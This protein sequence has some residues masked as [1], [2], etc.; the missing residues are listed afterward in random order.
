MISI[1]TTIKTAKLLHSRLHGFHAKG[2]PNVRWLHDPPPMNKSLPVNDINIM[3]KY[4]VTTLMDQDH[5]ALAELADDILDEDT[6]NKLDTLKEFCKVLA[7]HTTA[8]ELIVYPHLETHET[9][10]YVNQLRRE[11]QETQLELRKMIDTQNIDKFPE[12]WLVLQHHMHSEETKDFPMLETTFS[13]N[14]IFTMGY[15]FAAV[16]NSLSMKD[17]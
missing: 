8:E 2:L 4:K 11:H 7:Q 5:D 13:E 10:E 3:P 6:P 12:V 16:K 1:K 9:K 15:E 17:M 14:D